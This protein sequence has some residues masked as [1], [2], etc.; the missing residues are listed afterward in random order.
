MRS[1]LIALLKNKLPAV[2]FPNPNK[3]K[4]ALKERECSNVFIT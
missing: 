1:G 4:I 2:L 3:I